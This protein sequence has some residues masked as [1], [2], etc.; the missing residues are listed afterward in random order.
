[1]TVWVGC[2]GCHTEIAT[3]FSKPRNDEPRITKLPRVAS[4]SRNDEFVCAVIARSETTKQSTNHHSSPFVIASEA[5]QSTNHK[6]LIKK[7][8][9]KEI[10]IIYQVKELIFNKIL[11]FNFQFS[12]SYTS[13]VSHFVRRQAKM[14]MQAYHFPT[15]CFNFQFLIFNFQFLS[16]PP[17]CFATSPLTKGGKPPQTTEPLPKTEEKK[18]SS[19]E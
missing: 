12:I 4:N 16:Q 11:I 15:L 18:N 10:T 6:T 19:I 2:S 14:I 7:H 13:F 5:K 9:R 17:C 3:A 8:K 1:M